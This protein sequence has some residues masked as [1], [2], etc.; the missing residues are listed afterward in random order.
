MPAASHAPRHRAGAG[1]DP[2]RRSGRRRLAAKA[3]FLSPRPERPRPRRSRGQGKRGSLWVTSPLGLR[4]GVRAAKQLINFIVSVKSRRRDPLCVASL[5]ESTFACAQHRPRG[6][7]APAARQ[8]ARITRCA[9]AYLQHLCWPR[10]ARGSARRGDVWSAQRH[11][12]R[13]P[14]W[15]LACWLTSYRSRLTRRNWNFVRLATGRAPR[16]KRSNYA[17]HTQ[18]VRRRGCHGAAARRSSHRC[19]VAVQGGSAATPT[20]SL[21]ATGSAATA[22]FTRPPSDRAQAAGRGRLGGPRRRSRRPR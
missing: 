8:A 2:P 19:V 16:R 22:S 4:V 5:C 3:F 14:R 7:G 21:Q 13:R 20:A 17:S 15:R 10:R 1:R 11:G 18:T 6:G 12:W 9:R